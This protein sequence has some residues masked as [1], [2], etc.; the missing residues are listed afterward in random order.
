[1]FEAETAFCAAK[2]EEDR[3]DALTALEALG[4]ATVA[5]DDA[6]ALDGAPFSSWSAYAPR[7]L[8]MNARRRMRRTKTR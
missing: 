5:E 4:G 8:R 7:D 6:S 2:L 3:A 1:M